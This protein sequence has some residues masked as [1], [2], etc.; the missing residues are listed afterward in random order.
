MYVNKD[1]GEQ[2][3]AMSQPVSALDGVGPLAA[4]VFIQAGYFTVGELKASRADDCRIQDAIY[5]IKASRPEYSTAFW[6][7]L[8]TRCTNIIFRLQSSDAAPFIPCTFMCPLSLDWF[9][10]PV[11]TPSGHSYERGEIVEWIQL[12]GTDPI[13]R[14]PITVTELYPNK[15]LLVTQDYYRMR[16]LKFSILL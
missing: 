1:T 2:L 15:A 3:L 11:V 9:T 7:R 10:D 13:T 16:Q 12:Q 6:R 5:R 4:E 14:Q 8:R